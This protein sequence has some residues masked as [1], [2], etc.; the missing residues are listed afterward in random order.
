[1]LAATALQPHQFGRAAAD[2]E[3]EN[4]V[5]PLIDE[6]FGTGDR[7]AGFG[8]T[9]DDLELE[10]CLG[11][12]PGD[13]LRAVLSNAT[14]FRGNEPPP[15]DL[16]P[17]ELV[18]ADAERLDRS[19]HGAVAE[20]A[21]QACAFAEANDPGKGIDNG[22]SGQARLRQEQPAIVGAK[23][24]RAIYEAAGAAA[25]VLHGFIAVG[26]IVRLGPFAAPVGGH[27]IIRPTAARVQFFPPGSQTLARPECQE[28]AEPI[29]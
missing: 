20:P 4:L 17:N 26:T 9:V 1:M 14:G 15:R 6:G 25:C 27:G 12:N 7:Q 8:F 23:I 18:G 29:A 10:T 11:V 28:G 3:N 21:R 2:V 19:R 5:G 22:E 16:S 13:E 24:E